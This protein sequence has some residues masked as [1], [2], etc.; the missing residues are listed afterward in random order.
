VAQIRRDGGQALAVVADLSDPA[1]PAGLF[2]AAALI[3]GNVI[4]LR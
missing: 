1:T 2:D 4:T 3:T